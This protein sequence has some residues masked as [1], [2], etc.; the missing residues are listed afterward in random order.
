MSFPNETS[1]WKEDYRMYQNSRVP[2]LAKGNAGV[3]FILCPQSLAQS[4]AY[5]AFN[6]FWLKEQFPLLL[7]HDTFCVA[8]YWIEYPAGASSEAELNAPPL[9]LF[10][11][12]SITTDP[13]GISLQMHRFLCRHDNMLIPVLLAVLSRTFFTVLTLTHNTLF[14]PAQAPRPSL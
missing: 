1:P 6:K 12:L 14:S 2:P 8:R 5:E 13:R 11:S 10:V 9:T 3:G 4:R 7:I